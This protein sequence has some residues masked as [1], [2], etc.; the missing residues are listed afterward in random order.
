MTVQENTTLKAAYAGK[1][2]ADL[3]ENTAEQDRI[4]AEIET[5]Q[6]QLA[7]LETDHALLESM[8][9]ALGE[10]TGAV[11][12]P[13]RAAKKTAAVA[14]KAAVKKTADAVAP[15]KAG[16]KKDAANK[17]TMVAAKKTAATMGGAKAANTGADKG[18]AL[19]EL[20]H[21]HLSSQSEPRTAREIAKALADANPG[22]NVNDSLVRTTTERLVARSRVDRIKQGS[23]VYY[24]AKADAA[25]A[26]SEP[27]ATATA[28]AS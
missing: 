26:A 5:L 19:T 20:I 13:R 18:P 28:A 27:A 1:V 8:S 9:A 16:A 3:A 12:A 2:A 4:R 22:R 23:T 11:P 7:T 17:T 21:A 25:P 14:K 10:T 6:A 15:K 24:T